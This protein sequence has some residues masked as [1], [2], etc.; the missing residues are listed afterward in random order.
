[1]EVKEINTDFEITL[2]NLQAYIAEVC[3]VVRDKSPRDNAKLWDRL[4]K[5]SYGNKPSSTFSFIPCVLYAED[6]LPMARDNVQFFGYFKNGKYY[7][8]AREVL[9]WGSTI[10]DMLDVVDFS[11]YRAFKCVAPYFVY[12]QIR[13]HTQM[14]F[15]S[16]S[17]RYTASTHGYYKPREIKMNDDNWEFSIIDSSPIEIENFM[18]DNGVIR[19]EV[20]SRGK[21]MLQKRVFSIG[22]SFSNPNSFPHFLNERGKSKHTQLETREFVGLIEKEIENV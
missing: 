21:D 8:N 12:Q 10:C 2:E 18:K 20:Y 11:D 9:N 5:E 19:R 7:T 3:S 4:M 17:A 6:V 15:I 22:G 16:H 1:M 13:T 14:Q